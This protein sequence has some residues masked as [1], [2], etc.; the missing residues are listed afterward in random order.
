[1]CVLCCSVHVLLCACAAVHMCQIFDKGCRKGPGPA[2]HHH[3]QHIIAILC[4]PHLNLKHTRNKIHWAKWAAQ[5][6]SLLWWCSWIYLPGAAVEGFMQESFCSLSSQLPGIV[7]YMSPFK[8]NHSHLADP[9]KKPLIV[10]YSSWQGFVQCP[11]GDC[12]MFMLSGVSYFHIR[13]VV[14]LLFALH[15]AN[16]YAI[17]CSSKL[18]MHAM[19]LWSRPIVSA[20]LYSI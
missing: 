9:L 3:R 10:E 16:Y 14:D 19:E 4:K 2:T 13:K 12:I 1:M 6:V 11:I 17:L 8:P 15:V 7:V 20:T 5:E 18:A